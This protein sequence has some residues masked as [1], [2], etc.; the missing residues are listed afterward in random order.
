MKYNKAF[1]EEQLRTV[2][3]PGAVILSL[4][5]RGGGKT[6]TAVA[7]CEEMIKGVYPSL[8]KKITL[9]T[10]I[11][12]VRKT[13]DGFSTETPPG[14]YNIYT[15]RDLF[16]IVADILERDG[17]K[18]TLIILL[19]DE[20]QNFLQ[21][22]SARRTTMNEDMK[23]FTGILRKFN[24][25]MWLLTPIET[26][27]GPAFRGFID[28]DNPANVTAEFRKNLAQNRAFIKRWHL[29]IDERSIVRVQTSSRER[30]Q[31]LFVPV[32]SWTR[33][34]EDPTL[35][36]G[37]YIYDNLS[38][39]DFTVGDGFD[40]SKFV[41]AISNGS[42]YELIP[43]I[44]KFYEDMDSGPEGEPAS[45]KEVQKLIREREKQIAVALLELGV[46]RPTVAKA[47][48]VSVKSIGDWKRDA[49]TI[50]S[51]KTASESGEKEEEPAEEEVPDLDEAR[52]EGRKNREGSSRGDIYLSTPPCTEEAAEA[53]FSPGE[54]GNGTADVPEPASASDP[55]EGVRIPDGEYSLDGLKVY[56]EYYLGERIRA[57][58][59]AKQ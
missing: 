27:I 9:I 23:K 1:H 12:F 51:Q 43:K 2:F 40:F 44:R 58:E 13:E 10:N 22:E 56:G 17:R 11:I 21:G 59:E 57:K 35:R 48:G 16:P 8:P 28:A 5:L 30:P 39:A 46:K 41:T 7:F 14:V 19:L 34:P 49:A 15:M 52:Q 47:I 24:M 45:D 42:S 36:V 20:A 54:E 6:H 37:D 18:D 38:S 4:G 3:R 50:K 55:G 31:R 32:T 25:A 33:A 26:N 29:A 53:R